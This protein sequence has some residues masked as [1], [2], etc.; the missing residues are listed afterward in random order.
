M[1]ADRAARSNSDRAAPSAWIG[2]GSGL[3]R[4][5]KTQILKKSQPEFVFVVNLPSTSLVGRWRVRRNEKGIYPIEQFHYDAEK[6]QFTCPQR[7]TLRYWGIHKHSKQHVYRAN[8][9]DCGQCP[10]NE[11]CTRATYRS[12]SYHIYEDDIDLARKLTKTRGYRISQRM[13]KR[14]E[15]LFGEAKECMG[16]RRM[17]SRRALFVREQVL[18]TAAKQNIKI[19]VRLLARMGPERKA[20]PQALPLM[21]GLSIGF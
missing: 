19:M 16:F 14:V 1:F 3:Y 7:K 6:D 12:L 9:K 2:W 13:R 10:V 20:E 21:T 15:E 4:L 5:L 18:L 8:S 11:Q 17:K